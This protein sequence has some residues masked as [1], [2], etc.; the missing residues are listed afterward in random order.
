M[1]YRKRTSIIETSRGDNNGFSLIELLVVL[2]LLVAIAGIGTAYYGTVEEDK[3]DDLTRIELNQL[4]MAAKQFHADTGFWPGNTD[5]DNDTNEDHTNA[6]DWSI[7]TD[8][9]IYGGSWD[10]V[11]NRGWRGP[12]TSQVL[13]DTVT[14]SNVSEIDVNG[15]D[16]D[17]S[18]SPSDTT[19]DN[20]ELD[21]YGRAY[22]LLFTNNR[23]MI[24]S[25][26]KDGVFTLLGMNYTALGSAISVGECDTTPNLANCEETLY[27]AYCSGNTLTNDDDLVMCP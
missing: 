2:A 25:P 5:L 10:A 22:V 20:V 11:S 1:R 19:T 21:P 23:S 4:A 17:A 3:K 13:T 8:T 9:T 16:N 18:A 7:L 12:Y 15:L 27:L 24:I 6:F 14:I 26:G